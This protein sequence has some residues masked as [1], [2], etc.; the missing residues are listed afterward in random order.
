MRKTRIFFHLIIFLCASIF[1]IHGVAS[2]TKVH[3]APSMDTNQVPLDTEVSTDT[4]LQVIIQSIETTQEQLGYKLEQLKQEETEEL[5]LK[6]I[7]EINSL[8]TRIEALEKNFHSI[9]TGVDLD[10]FTKEPKKAFDWKEELEELLGPIIKEMRSLTAHPRDIERLRSDVSYYR[11]QIATIQKGIQNIQENLEKS[12]DQKVK[13]YLA[14][15]KE[16]WAYKEQQILNQLAVAEYQLSEKMKEE[17]S[18]FQSLQSIFKAFFRSRGRNL[19]FALLAFI[20]VW[21]LFHFLHVMALKMVPARRSKKKSLYTRLIALSYHISTF[22]CATGALLLM[23]YVSGDWVLLGLAV[24]FLLGLAWAARQALPRFWGEAKLLLNLGPVRENERLVYQGL[25]WK[26]KSLNFFTSLVNPQLKGG[27]I[28]L[29]L[30]SL[31]DLH[32]RPHQSDEPWFPCKQSDWVILA[33]GTYGKVLN[34]TPEIVE[35]LLLG[36]SHKTYPTQAFL[37]QNPNNLST[38]F[39]LSVTFGIDYRHQPIIIHEIPDKLQ[40]MLKER[41]IQEGFG[42]DIMNNAVEFKNAG[43]SSLDLEVLAD[44]SGEA[45]KDYMRLS[46]LIQRICVDACNQNGWIIPFTQL[47]LHYADDARK[48]KD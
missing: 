19:I 14:N 36:G 5:K 31:L 45:A 47:T 27:T 3:E 13:K 10:I 28:R 25:P 6:I 9:A 38:N 46:R 48:E 40:R 16:S 34:Q 8:N 22:I 7:N 2:G 37:N 1:F 12:E 21:L 32:S 20:G 33:D 26:V 35:L 23:L 11:V 30:R 18:F 15:L 4:T 39:R 17:R 41:L 44:F 24:I 43:T 29:P 42:N